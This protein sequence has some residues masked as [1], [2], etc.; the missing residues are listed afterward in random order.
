MKFVN[1]LKLFRW[2]HGAKYRSIFGH[3]TTKNDSF[4]IDWGGSDMLMIDEDKLAVT[5][6]EN[7][8]P[9]Y[10]DEVKV[11]KSTV[12]GWLD[13]WDDFSMEF[14][15][16]RFDTMR[17]ELKLSIDEEVFNKQWVPFFR[18]CAF[19]LMDKDKNKWK[20]SETIDGLKI[21]K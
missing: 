17:S 2:R 10:G 11:M 14:W 7:F 21:Y 5:V 6:I 19:I 13:I 3:L 16:N 4:V 8:K 1:D 20:P 18:D 15:T 12:L 9:G